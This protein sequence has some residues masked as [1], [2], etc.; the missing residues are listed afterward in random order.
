VGDERF[1]LLDKQA[2]KQTSKQRTNKPMK[3]TKYITLPLAGLAALAFSVEAHAAVLVLDTGFDL[4]N[5]DSAITDTE[6]GNLDF[7]GASKLV[8]TV[9]VKGSALSPDSQAGTVTYNGTAMTFAV[10]SAGGGSSYG[11]VGIYYLDN[12]GSVGVGD[13][14]VQDPGYSL[15][16]SALVL[17]GTA[18]DFGATNSS[19]SAAMV[20]LTTTSA[21]SLVFAGYS[22][23]SSSAVAASPL[24]P[25]FGGKVGSGNHASGYQSVATVSTIN[26]AFTTAAARPSTVAAEFT[27]AAIPEPTTT[28]LL[29]LG[30]LALILRRR[31]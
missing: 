28:A 26:P 2:N 19:N 6:L 10:G 18:A 23:G 17:S 29:G 15:G 30:G 31:K 20:S 8:V 12:P 16:V 3:L 9:G 4:N 21:G 11:W 5:D 25:V 13:L 24:T 7:T 14:V 27:A 22:D 1:D